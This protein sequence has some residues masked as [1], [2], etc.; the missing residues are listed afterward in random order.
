M[1]STWGRI[2]MRVTSSWG[3]MRATCCLTFKP[4]ET[5]PHSRTSEA[6]IYNSL[7]LDFY[8]MFWVV[9]FFLA[10]KWPENGL[11]NFKRHFQCLVL[12]CTIIVIECIEVG[13]PIFIS[14][15]ASIPTN[16]LYFPFLNFFLLYFLL[17][18]LFPELH[19]VLLEHCTYRCRDHLTRNTF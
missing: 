6:V 14:N 12:L 16:C 4:H 18:A 19:K 9:C 13:D 1:R 7:V 15:P 10:R 11:I 2:F 8:T 5:D 17:L 3:F